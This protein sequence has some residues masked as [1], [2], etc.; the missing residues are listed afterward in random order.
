MRI[1]LWEVDV[2]RASSAVAAGRWF[3]KRGKVTGDQADFSD[4]FGI[5]VPTRSRSPPLYL[6]GQFLNKSLS[7]PER[8]HEAII[9]GG[10]FLFRH[11]HRMAQHA[12]FFLS[13]TASL[14]LSL[15]RPCI[16]HSLHAT[17]PLL[18]LRR[19]EVLV[20]GVLVAVHL[21][22]RHVL[23]LRTRCLVHLDEALEKQAG[24]KSGQVGH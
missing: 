3:L 7:R 4:L 8:R 13:F 17:P 16:L 23:L 22:A 6:D 11:H 21:H 19:L 5:W 9:H 18:C 10:R 20:R 2:K 24:D 1:L 12:S 15:S 14:S